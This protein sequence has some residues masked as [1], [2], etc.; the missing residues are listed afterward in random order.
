MS[1]SQ[2][3]SGATNISDLKAR[4]GLK[5]KPGAPG[6]TPPP[7]GSSRGLVA[8]P[9]VERKSRALSV[10]PP[11]GA[12]PPAPEIPDASEDPFGAM[13]AMA[14]AQQAVAGPEIV[15]VNDG[16]P[17]ESVER[18]SPL[19]RYGLTA[20]MI[21]VPLVLGLLLGN[22]TARSSVNDE[23]RAD[24]V[25]VGEDINRV[26]KGLQDV[27]DALLLSLQDGP[28]GQAFPVND[29]KLTAA[30][31]TDSLLPT[32]DPEIFRKRFYI[33]DGGLVAQV[34]EFYMNVIS[35]REMIDEH[36]KA[37]ANDAKAM[38]EGKTRIDMAKPDEKVNRYLTFYRYGIIVQADKDKEFGARMVEIGPP[39]CQD[40]KASTTG[41]CEDGPPIGFG[42]RPDATNN[43]GFA[44]TEL[45]I[46]QEGSVPAEKLLPL[47][48]TPLFESLQKGSEQSI[49][50]TAYLRRVTAL[51][52]LVKNT[53]DLGS[54][55]AGDLAKLKV[56]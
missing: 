2:K 31:A 32:I 24:A 19:V 3:K 15:V 23:A 43:V 56:D 30:L 18:K 11:P 52:E 55:L 6:V 42:T 10:P 17:V 44:P 1:P 53:I 46:A 28:G 41:K 16:K 5:K 34:L 39:Y 12:A 9:G 13:R 33:L 7:G 4:L 37:T 22:V 14:S 50:E 8:P 20:A 25:T 35:I 26:R 36:L 54:A 45:G 29:E 27:Q 48:P 47:I 38:A 21:G 49:A 40:R 51:N